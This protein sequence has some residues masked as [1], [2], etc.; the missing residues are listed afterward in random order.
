[1]V[2]MQHTVLYAAEPRGLSLDEKILP[3]YLKDLG[4]D[5]YYDPFQLN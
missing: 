3:E 4:W 2:G 1:M 5:W